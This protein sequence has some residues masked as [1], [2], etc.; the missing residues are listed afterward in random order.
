LVSDLILFDQG[1]VCVLA[2]VS[3]VG[4]GRTVDAP[5]LAVLVL[6][7]LLPDARIVLAG[8]PRHS[9]VTD[10]YF[11]SGTLVGRQ[12]LGGHHRRVQ[13]GLLGVGVR[14]HHGVLL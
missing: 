8:L 7:A 3:V 1:A 9:L 5:L 14:G 2:A 10:K 11:V 13:A 12:H 6:E 4:M